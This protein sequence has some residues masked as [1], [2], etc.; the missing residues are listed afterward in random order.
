MKGNSFGWFNYRTG[1]YDYLDGQIE[2]YSPYIPQDNAVQGLYAA[3]VATGKTPLVA[4]QKTLEAVC[5]IGSKDEV[6]S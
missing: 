5:G 2:D 1:E 3:H 4:C 6:Q